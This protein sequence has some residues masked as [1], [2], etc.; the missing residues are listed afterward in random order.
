MQDFVKG[1]ARS[2]PLSRNGHRLAVEIY[3]TDAEVMFNLDEYEILGEYVDGLSFVRKSGS[4]NTATALDTMVSDVFGR[5]GERGSAR[6]VG[7]LISDGQ[8]SNRAE[9]WASAR[10]ARD[11]GVTML[12]VGVGAGTTW[13]RQELETIAS[14]ESSANVFY[15]ADYTTL[16]ILT[17]EIVT[18]VCN[19]KEIYKYLHIVP[20]EIEGAKLPLY[21]VAV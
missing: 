20:L 21:K 18:A 3:A 11:S 8:S 16:P 1:L 15:S 4:T 7:V 19:G 6:N 14:R 2:L 5:S 13:N 9:T 12:C 10:E 17:D